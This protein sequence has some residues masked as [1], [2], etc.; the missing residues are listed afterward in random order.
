M[1][2][3]K[4]KKKRKR[5]STRV[6]L[7]DIALRCKV[8]K[9]TV[10]RVLNGHLNEFPVSDKMVA[11]VQEA[12]NQL[13]YRPNR[14]ARAIRNQR[15]HLIGL[16]FLHIDRSQLTEDQVA[17]ENLV[18]GQFANSIISHP[19]FSDYDLVFH[20]RVEKDAQPLREGDFKF[21]LLEGMIYLTPSET[22]REFLDFATPKSPIVL[23]GQLD[24]AEEKV[25]C[26]DINN[27]KMAQMAVEHLIETGRR[28]ILVLIPGK[29]QHLCCIKDRVL[30]YHDA[31]AQNGI[32]P[33]DALIQTVHCL[34]ENVAETLQNLP[35]L[36][37]IDA[38]FCP[39]DDLA[40][41]CIA[42][43]REL[44]KRIPEDIALIGFDDLPLAKHTTPTLSTVRRPVAKQAHAAIDLL[45][46]ILKKEI[47]YEPG[48]HEIETE[49]IIRQST[50]GTE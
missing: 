24:G 29:L 45:L 46:K 28:N 48:F 23:L 34:P 16:S 41:L 1:E 31:L 5:T 39:T 47:P 35:S 2:Q 14:L 33:S 37:E 13:G 17:Y 8:S 3:K 20:D 27:R 11:H 6:T 42:P 25:P 22:H 38:I 21:D 15:T 9:A 7:E 19:G 49:L 12:A 50:G 30:G 4:Q 10:S 18:M 36:N 40:A 32:A 44:G 26:I 43:L